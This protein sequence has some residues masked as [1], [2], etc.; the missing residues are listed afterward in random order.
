MSS[1][2]LLNDGKQQLS[3]ELKALEAASRKWR[4]SLLCEIEG[5]GRLDEH[6]GRTRQREFEDQLAEVRA[7]YADEVPERSLLREG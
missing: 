4:P 6:C 3:D 1:D 5:I 2:R 7:V